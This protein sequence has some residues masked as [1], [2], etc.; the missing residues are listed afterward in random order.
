MC[1]DALQSQWQHKRRYLQEFLRCC[2]K[3]GSQPSSR[4]SETRRSAHT[5][6]HL[7]T[8]AGSQVCDWLTM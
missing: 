7:P 8:S 6:S 5:C 2:L 3:E 1:V 4:C